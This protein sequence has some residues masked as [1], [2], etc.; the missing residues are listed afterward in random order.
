MVTRM[1]TMRNRWVCMR[2]AK[3]TQCFSISLS[4]THGSDFHVSNNSKMRISMAQYV[5]TVTRFLLFL[6]PVVS[7]KSEK[8]ASFCLENFLKNVEISISI[9][10]RF[11]GYQR[12]YIEWK[13]FLH[14]NTTSASY[15]SY[16]NWLNF[17]QKSQLSWISA[18]HLRVSHSTNSV[19]LSLMAGDGISCVE[20]TKKCPNRF[21]KDKTHT[22]FAGCHK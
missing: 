10:N 15:D 2:C 13:S 17:R 8:F 18:L 16:F 7:G 14:C 6:K 12:S 4:D 22:L 19:R 1:A 3:W 5:I 9:E 21:T 11:T 20:Q